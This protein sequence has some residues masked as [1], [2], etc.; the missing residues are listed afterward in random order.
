MTGSSNL[1]KLLGVTR[2]MTTGAQTQLKAMA[3]RKTKAIVLS[4]G[5][6]AAAPISLLAASAGISE[7]KLLALKTTPIDT[8]PA[9]LI[10]S[11]SND[12]TRGVPTPLVNERPA[13]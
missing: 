10:A 6:T 2:Y 11:G 3:S 8:A 13:M 5:G 4:K 9:T 12:R 1:S 7:E